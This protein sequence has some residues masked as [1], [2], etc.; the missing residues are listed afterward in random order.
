HSAYRNHFE[1]PRQPHSG[2]QEENGIIILRDGLQNMARDLK[3]M[4]RIWILFHFNYSLGCK[5]TV[6]PPRDT[7]SRGLFATR[8]PHRPNPIGLSCVRLINVVG[9]KI[10][11][12]DH[13]LLHG[14]PVLDIKP[15]LSY[16]ESFPDARC[17]WIDD[18]HE[19]APDHRWD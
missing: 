2:A 14:T 16:C 9:L 7:E 3:G 12:R 11:I 8:S 6:V 13:D 19:D 1:V 10:F 4:D 17:G 15:Y 18:L 5:Q